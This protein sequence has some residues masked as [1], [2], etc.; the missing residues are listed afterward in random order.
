MAFHY[1]T[2]DQPVD[3]ADFV[4][5]AVK[6]DGL[7]QALQAVKRHVGPDTIL[8]SLLNGIASEDDIAQVYG[9]RHLLHAVCVGIDA[10]R[11]GTSVQYS[12]I[13][14]IC[15]GNATAH[16]LTDD[17]AAVKALFDRAGIPCAVHEDI[18][19]TMWWKFMINVGVN[20]ASAIL[21][22]PYGKFQTDS[23]AHSVMQSLMREVLAL[24]AAV[25][26]D[27][28]EDALTQFDIV[29]KQLSPAGKTSMLQD[30][31]AGRRTEIEQL[32]GMVRRLGQEHGIATPVNDFVYHAIRAMENG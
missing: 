9:D 31:E 24:S 26:V 15:F 29:L 14:E 20:Q 5:I 30:V 32:A 2:P 25:G 4:V 6:Y 13:G 17:V 7:E 27:L 8:M 3:P 18:Q 21:R 10:V 22:A 16:D 19:R 23:H 1:V 28:G 11:Q 12:G